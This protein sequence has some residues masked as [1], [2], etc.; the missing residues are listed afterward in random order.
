MKTTANGL[1]DQLYWK[2]LCKNMEKDKK[3]IETN[4]YNELKNMQRMLDEEKKK[5][6]RDT[7]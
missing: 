5:M 6:F 1:N 4:S 2:Y 7:K 3:A